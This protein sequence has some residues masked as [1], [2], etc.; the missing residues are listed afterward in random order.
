MNGIYTMFMDQET[1]HKYCQLPLNLKALEL[2]FT[3]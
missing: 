3:F 1:Q 2:A